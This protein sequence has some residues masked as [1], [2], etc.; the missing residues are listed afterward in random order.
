[1]F[2]KGIKQPYKSIHAAYKMFYTKILFNILES[3]L[4]VLILF[5]PVLYPRMR[6]KFLGLG[7]WHIPHLTAIE[8]LSAATTFE[9]LEPVKDTDIQVRV[10]AQGLVQWNPERATQAEGPDPCSPAGLV[11]PY[12]FVNFLLQILRE[13]GGSVFGGTLD[14]FQSALQDWI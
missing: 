8:S 2:L 14:Y 12:F 11:I 6:V 9:P 1:M 3:T 4:N 5:S 7:T 10:P 13:W